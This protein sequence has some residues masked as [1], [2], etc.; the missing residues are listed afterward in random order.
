MTGYIQHARQKE[1]E[2]KSGDFDILAPSPA[3]EKYMAQYAPEEPDQ[4]GEEDG[5]LDEMK[6]RYPSDNQHILT[7]DAQEKAHFETYGQYLE[8]M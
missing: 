1:K 5:M 7:H 4:Q 6:A 2:E 8:M 3:Y